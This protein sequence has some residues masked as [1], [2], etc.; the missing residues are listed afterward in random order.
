MRDNSR[1]SASRPSAL[2]QNRRRR[3]SAPID[4]KCSATYDLDIRFA[5]N[6][7]PILRWRSDSPASTHS[8]LSLT[9]GSNRTNATR[10]KS[11][12]IYSARTC[13]PLTLTLPH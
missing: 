10:N 13:G 9:T 8:H 2:G 12:S 7:L 4:E 6:S 3:S 11:R 5:P 1:T